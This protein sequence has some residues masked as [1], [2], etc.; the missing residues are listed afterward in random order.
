MPHLKILSP[1]FLCH[2]FFFPTIWRA[3]CLNILH[4]FN[5]FCSVEFPVSKFCVMVCSFFWNNHLMIAS[6]KRLTLKFSACV[7]FPS[8]LLL[9]CHLGGNCLIETN[10]KWS[11][12]NSKHLKTLVSRTHFVNLLSTIISPSIDWWFWGCFIVHNLLVSCCYC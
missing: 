9:L 2:F 11:V 3:T 7:I 1:L 10:Q 5:H 12:S 4:I 8:G 6:F